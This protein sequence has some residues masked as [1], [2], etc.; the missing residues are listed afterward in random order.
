MARRL[1]RP[2]RRPRAEAPAAPQP[3]WKRWWVRIAAVAVP[4]AVA[5]VTLALTDVY[6]LLKTKVSAGPPSGLKADAGWPAADGCDLVTAA[7]MVKGGPPIT[8]LD[9]DDFEKDPRTLVTEQDG[10]SWQD[11]ILSLTFSTEGA[12]A[13]SISAVRPH[14]LGRSTTVSYD[15]VLRKTT[16]CGGGDDPSFLRFD[17][18]KNRLVSIEGGKEKVRSEEGGSL[19]TG[20]TVKKGSPLY[21]NFDVRSCTASY[22]WTLEIEYRQGTDRKTTALGPFRSAGGVEGIPVYDLK[23]SESGLGRELVDTGTVT[24]AGC[25]GEG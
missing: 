15:W 8:E 23:P 22:T 4:V 9:I 12:E 17:L 10:A 21:A 2:P 1:V 20:E 11:G 19:L 16:S 18:D 24:E 7:A 25:G 5:L 13:I 6:G 3:W 14:I